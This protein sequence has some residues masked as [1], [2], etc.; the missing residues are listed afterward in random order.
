MAIRAPAFNELRFE[1]IGRSFGAVDAL[2]DVS[3]NVRRGEFIALLG[4]SGCGK[5][6]TLNILAGLLAATSGAIWLD[7]RRIDA[8]RPEERGFGM[9]FQNYALFPHMSVRR[10]IGFGLAMRK[11]SREEIARR[12]REAVAL[13]RLEGQEDKLPGQLS[14]GQ[15]QRVAIARA[16]V[17]EPPLVLMDEPLS[18]LDAKLRLEMRAE[19]RR[20]HS[21]L[22]ATTIYVTHDQ[23]EA[24]SLAD[25][26]VVMRAGGIRQIGSPEEV[27]E[28][29]VTLDVAEFMGFRNRLKGEI[30]ESGAGWATVRVGQAELRGAL[31]APL[32][33]GAQAI[34]AMRP[35]DLTPAE[36]DASTLAVKVTSG[37]FRGDCFACA[38]VGADGTEIWFVAPRRV[39]LGEVVNLRANPEC[40]RLYP[41]DEA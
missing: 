7:E 35:G 31:A 16:I 39:A 27:Y 26:V 21:G 18:N 40:A 17:I 8:L 36:A 41:S 1:G 9:V 24:L 19:I 3:L 23:E 14:G 13:V 2:R 25:R 30:V 38:G 10:N 34:L 22:G 33:R 29:P 32:T 11:V 37:E 28:R 12:T 5:S 20:I 4:P 15:Q 6:T